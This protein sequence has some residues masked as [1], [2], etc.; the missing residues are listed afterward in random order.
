MSC[1]FLH[2]FDKNCCPVSSA[3]HVLA[4]A[5]VF[6]IQKLDSGLSTFRSIDLDAGNDALVVVFGVLCPIISG[7]YP[8]NRMSRRDIFGLD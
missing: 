3:I 5:T 8:A 4:L 2:Q 6:C 7:L 1:Y